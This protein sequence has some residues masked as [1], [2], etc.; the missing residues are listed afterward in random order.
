MLQL[1]YVM[2]KNHKKM[3]RNAGTEGKKFSG[4]GIFY[5]YS[6]L[7]QS[8]IGIPRVILV[9][10]YSRIT[11]VLPSYALITGCGNKLEQFLSQDI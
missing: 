10:P 7:Y 5:R 11:Q 4:G 6:R 3:P 8:G 1:L 2:L 9:P